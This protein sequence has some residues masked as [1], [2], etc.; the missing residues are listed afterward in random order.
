MGN[1]FKEIKPCFKH[2]ILS[3]NIFDIL[4]KGTP[5]PKINRHIMSNL[6]NEDPLLLSNYVIFISDKIILIKYQ[7]YTKLK[8]T[9]K[10]LDT[11]QEI[12]AFLTKSINNQLKI[13]K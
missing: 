9:N 12:P 5:H 4:G 8:H 11:V 1:M 3:I 6:A 13:L 10:R 7:K 2:V